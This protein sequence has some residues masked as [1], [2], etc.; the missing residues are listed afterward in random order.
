MGAPVRPTPPARIRPRTIIYIDGFNLYY[1]AVKDVPALK[2]LNIER[3]CRLLRPDDDIVAIRYFSA[4]VEGPTRPN[5]EMYLRALATTPLVSVVLGRFK[6][7]N[8]TCRLSACMHPGERRFRVP[9]EKR[10]DVS[11]ATYMMDDAYRNAC[12]HLIIFSGDSDLVPP[13]A[14]VR[15]RFPEKKITVYVPSRNAERGA[16]VELRTACHVN[17][18]LP[19]ILLPKSQFPNE[20][21][22]G[23]AG[24]IRRPAD[25][26]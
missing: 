19:L 8:I 17:R 5:Q 9:E 26:V 25:W 24:V 10:T 1:G 11:I 12:D 21:P 2:W 15:G 16:A 23:G 6:K 18:D 20:I 3:F 13:V 22:D 4:L 14:M 7:K